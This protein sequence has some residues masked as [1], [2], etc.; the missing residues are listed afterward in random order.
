MGIIDIHTHM[1][2]GIDDGAGDSDM[3]MTLMGMDYKQGVSGIFC[4]NHSYGM[5]H[6][7]RDYHRS[8]EEL[9]KAAE[10]RFPGLSLYKGC[11]ILC[12]REDMPVIIRNIKND[13]YPTM[14]GTNYVLLEFDPYGT[15]GMKEMT[16]CV[17]YV[18]DAGYIPII[19]HIE[20]YMPIYHDPLTDISR[21]RE[22]GCLMQIN[23]YSVEQDGGNAGGRS[24]KELANLFLENR[25]VDFAGTD[26]HRLD[27]KSS[28]A[29]A[30]AA[31]IREKYG[32]EYA[33]KVL[34]G[35]AENML[36]H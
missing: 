22:L 13:I 28:E 12:Y 18:L 16:Y 1:L 23:L 30:G 4:T 17:N 11:E 25:L 15:E 7:Y 33:E 2:Y 24:R 31:A 29:A 34:F 6:F 36:L 10:D 26:S 5:L 3:S 20:R 14:N 27:Y 8:F 9:S 19:A 35:N 21:L 32:A